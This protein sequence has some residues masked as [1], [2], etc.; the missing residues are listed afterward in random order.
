MVIRLIMIEHHQHNYN[1][2]HQYNNDGDDDHYDNN[3]GG[4]HENN[5]AN[6][7]TRSSPTTCLKQLF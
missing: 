1:G 7:S 3:D 2:A 6:R 4:H 5:N